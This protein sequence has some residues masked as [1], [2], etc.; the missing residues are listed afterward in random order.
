MCAWSA[1]SLIDATCLCEVIAV[2]AAWERINM[3][4]RFLLGFVNTVAAC[5]NDIRFFQKAL[6]IFFESNGREFE[7]G[8]FVHAIIYGYCGR[9]VIAEGQRHWRIVP[10]EIFIDLHYGNHVVNEIALA[11]QDGA[12]FEPMLQVRH[13]HINVLYGLVDLKLIGTIVKDRFFDEEHP[14]ILC[15]PAQ[16]VL[17]SLVYEVPAQVRK[18]DKID[19]AD[20]RPCGCWSIRNHAGI[21]TIYMPSILQL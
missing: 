4:M 20:M 12:F 18:A 2:D 21:C 13:D 9:Q 11:L 3:C 17:R 19:I 7:C 14:R 1:G 15:K 16:E 6:L 5:E 10:A 8:Q